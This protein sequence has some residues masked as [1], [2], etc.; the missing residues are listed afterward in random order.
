MSGRRNVAETTTIVAKNAVD[1]ADNISRCVGRFGLG[2]DD[3]ICERRNHCARYLEM[4]KDRE[5]FPDGYPS[6][7]SVRTGLCRDGGDFHIPAVGE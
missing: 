5:R 2:P 1:I 4:F 6:R 7:I 3:P